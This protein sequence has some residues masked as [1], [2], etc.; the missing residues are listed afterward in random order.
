[1]D[2]VQETIEALG[3][4]AIAERFSAVPSSISAAIRQNQFPAAWYVAL[5]DM[6][7]AKGLDPIPNKLFN[8]KGMKEAAAQ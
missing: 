1:M 6:A 3:R 8:M 4:P 2:T 7:K 5:Q